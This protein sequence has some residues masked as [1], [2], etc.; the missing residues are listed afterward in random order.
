M[1]VAIAAS[2]GSLDSQAS[3]VFGRCS[4]LIVLDLVDGDFK[5]FKIIPNPTTTEGGAGI[6]TARMV[7]DEGA[8]AIISGSVGPN[9]FEVLKQ[10][11]IKT[12]QMVPGTVEENLTLL[13]QGKLQNLDPSARGRRTGMGARKG[14]RG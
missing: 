13:S 5:D 7:G 1:K 12:Y 2:G 11:D 4:H 9:A 10:L 3:P 6:K 8:E 14:G